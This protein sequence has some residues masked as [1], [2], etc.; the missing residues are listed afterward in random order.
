MEDAPVVVE[1][2]KPKKKGKN[3]RVLCFFAIERHMNIFVFFPFGSFISSFSS[4]KMSPLSPYT[5][6][7]RIQGLPTARAERHTGRG[8]LTTSC[9]RLPTPPPTHPRTPPPTHPTPCAMPTKPLSATQAT[10]TTTVASTWTT[11][12]RPLPPAR[13]AYGTWIQRE[14]ATG[15]ERAEM[16]IETVRKINIE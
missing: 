1:P 9:I 8:R 10:I 2:T 13:W 6:S 5:P 12:G 15:W 14:R 16:E 3:W 7:H 11:P 4:T